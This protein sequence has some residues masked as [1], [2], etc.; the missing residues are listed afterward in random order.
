MNGMDSN[1]TE[2]RMKEIAVINEEVMNISHNQPAIQNG[3]EG[4]EEEDDEEWSVND[5]KDEEG[6]EKL[7][8]EESLMEH[9]I[10]DDE[11]EESPIE[12]D[13]NSN[14]KIK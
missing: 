6:E 9:R 2:Q 10:S 5:F 8:K 1:M 7:N 4:D 11:G 3:E 13:H 14:Q 12:T